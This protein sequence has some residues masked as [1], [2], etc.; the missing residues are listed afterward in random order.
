M[1]KLLIQERIK[2]MKTPKYT[3]PPTSNLGPLIKLA[4]QAN[5]KNPRKLENQ[6]DTTTLKK[7]ANQQ[8][9]SILAELI[10]KDQRYMKSLKAVQQQT[11]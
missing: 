9:G 5:T 2:K 11:K 3:G 7:I 10:K 8:K 1:T 6:A 4:N